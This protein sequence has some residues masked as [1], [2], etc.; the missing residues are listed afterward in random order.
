MAK[1]T[2]NNLFFGGDGDRKSVYEAL[3]RDF[4][5]DTWRQLGWRWVF[6]L[7]AAGAALSGHEE[8][9][10]LFVGMYALERAHARFIDNSNRNWAMHVI[11]WIEHN[12]QD[13]RDW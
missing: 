7:V 4:N 5:R 8:W 2:H 3:Q 9:L 10:W 11:D 1:L 6:A 13:N 12:R